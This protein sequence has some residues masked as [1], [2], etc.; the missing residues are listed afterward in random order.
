MLSVL[1]WGSAAVPERLRLPPGQAA[2]YLRSR[3]VTWL[4]L[5]SAVSAF[6]TDISPAL[7]PFRPIFSRI[8]PRVRP[9]CTVGVPFLREIEAAF[10]P[11]GIAI[12]W[13]AAIAW[14]YRL[15]HIADAEISHLH[16]R[17]PALEYRQARGATGRIPLHDWAFCRSIADDLLEQAS[18]RWP[19]N[20]MTGRRHSGCFGDALVVLNRKRIPVARH[21]PIRP[22]VGTE[23]WPVCHR[24]A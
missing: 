2:T 10:A 22:R 6:D 15:A 16:H 20:N 21:H 23:N 3:R 19:R 8:S 18:R 13:M 12:T 24:I 4:A 17:S 5:V 11:K 14:S 9:T 7:S 1:S